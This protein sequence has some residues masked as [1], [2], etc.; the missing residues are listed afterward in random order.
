LVPFLA[1]ESICGVGICELPW[2]PNSPQ[3]T[4]SASRTMMFG[5]RVSAAHAGTARTKT[6]ARE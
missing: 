4:S 5:L 1:I 2:N 3:P 6:A